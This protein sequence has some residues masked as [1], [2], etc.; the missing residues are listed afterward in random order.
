MPPLS[1]QGAQMEIYDCKVI[2]G[3]SRDNEVRK[4]AIPAAEIAMLRH[5][6]GDDSVL[7]IQHVGTSDI[8]DREVRDLLALSYGPGDVELS[9]AGPKI[10]KEVFGPPGVALPAFVEGVEL[11]SEKKVVKRGRVK[12]LR[13]ISPE[14]QIFPPIGATASLNAFED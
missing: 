4:Q 13:D 10:L 8:T 2:L 6:H 12:R 5:I 1:S 9:R 7:E 3:G 14:D 11:L